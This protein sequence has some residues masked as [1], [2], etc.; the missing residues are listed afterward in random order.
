MQ[1]LRHLAAEKKIDGIK[2]VGENRLNEIM[3]LI[4]RYLD[5]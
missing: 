4:E 3:V 2:G 1:M 5:V